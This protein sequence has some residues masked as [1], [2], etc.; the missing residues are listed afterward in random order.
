[1]NNA[2]PRTLFL[3]V[4]VIT[5]DCVSRVFRVS[6]LIL[7]ITRDGKW[8]VFGRNAEVTAVGVKAIPEFPPFLVFFGF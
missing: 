4:S 2:P 7:D 1:M 5:D 8:P 3:Q 6:Q